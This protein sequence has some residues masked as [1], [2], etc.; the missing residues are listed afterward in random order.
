[1]TL[2]RRLSLASILV[3][4]AGGL[5]VPT[6]AQER[7]NALPRVSPNAAVSQTVGVTEVRVTYGRPGVR[8]RSVFGDLVPYGEVWRTGANEATTISFS[9]P[10]QIEGESLD[11]GTYGLFTIPG[12]D[13]WT[14]IFNNTAEQWGAYNY[15]ASQ[16][17]LRVTVEPQTVEMTELLTFTFPEVTDTT[18]TMHLRWAEAGVPVRLSVNT[19]AVVSELANAAAQNPESWQ[20]PAQYAGYA[21]ENEAMLNDA[22]SW[23][24]ASV[25]TEKTFQN[26][27]LHARV[28]AANGRYEDAVRVAEEALSM[29][30]SMDET[31]RGVEQLQSRVAEWEEQ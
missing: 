18:A 28:L 6:Q 13:E 3:L 21:L 23:I 19:T 29:A 14:V 12:E 30:E 24:E 27:S 8:G 10:V 31:P 1:M 11:A 2:F 20:T 22:L 7:S 16:D 4:L 26:V 17:A 9:S 25:N 15:D 5:A